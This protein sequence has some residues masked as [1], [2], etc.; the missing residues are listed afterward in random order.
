MYIHTLYSFLV[1]IRSWE[2]CVSLSWLNMVLTIN[3]INKEHRSKCAR[4][5]CVVARIKWQWNCYHAFSSTFDKLS[6]LLWLTIIII[7]TRYIFI[8]EQFFVSVGLIWLISICKRFAGGLALPEGGEEKKRNWDDYIYC[9]YMNISR[10]EWYS[11]FK[12]K[13]LTQ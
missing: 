13:I 7:L 1:R 3:E 2:I 10:Y 4:I 11:K 6:S 9:I 12:T 5:E 8:F